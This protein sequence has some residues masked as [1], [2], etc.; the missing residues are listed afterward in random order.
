MRPG[1]GNFNGNEVVQAF[2]KNVEM[3]AK[4]KFLEAHEL[5]SEKSCLSLFAAQLTFFTPD[6]LVEV[7]CNEMLAPKVMIREP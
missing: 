1:K 5:N 4:K 6:F 2:V 3:H 7:L